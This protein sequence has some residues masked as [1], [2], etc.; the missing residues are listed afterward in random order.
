MVSRAFHFIYREIKGLHQAAYVLALFAFGSQILAVIRDR[1]L[2]HTFG[3]GGELD[4]YYTAFRIPDLLFV[5]FASILSVYVLLPF[6]ERSSTADA[7][8]NLLSQVFTLFLFVYTSIAVVLALTAPWYVSYLFPGYAEQAAEL[9]ILLQIL[10]LQPL[11][12]GISSICGVITQMHHRFVLYAIS[13]LVY[14]FGIIF[15]L[16]ALYPYFGLPGLVGGVVIGAVGH[17][18][19]Q[20]PFVRRSAVSFTAVFVF[21]W[22]EIWQLVLVALPRALT[23]S[24]HQIVLLVFISIATT[25][26]VGSVSVFQ[27]AY[28]IQSVPL[29][30]IGMSY[31][32]AAF[33]TLSHLFAKRD[34]AAFNLQ[35]LT[36]LRHIVFWSIPIIGLVVILRAHIVRVLLGSGEF[37]W[38][39][40]RLTAAVL[41]LFVVSL[42]AQAVLLLVIRAFYAGGR[43]VIPLLYSLISSVLAI[44]CAYGGLWLWRNSQELQLFVSSQFRL[45]AVPGSEVLVLAAAFTLGQ[46]VQVVM[47]L[48][49][50]RKTFSFRVYPLA[51]LLGQ[52]VIAAV[53]GAITAYGTLQFVVEGINQE[54]SIGIAL[55]GLAAGIAGTVAIV[56][57][58]WVLR[59]PEL[60]ETL[61]SFRKKILQTDFV[62][63]Q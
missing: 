29:A 42:A 22:K 12:L 58:Y 3:A 18:L 46:L 44:G 1:M 51:R 5:L 25:L 52:S 15:G 32:V 45:E 43:T 17:V 2:A 40:T 50:A 6:I 24:L 59:S 28:N 48:I 61:K 41:A 36:A 20:V 33:P 21:N 13:P 49:Q 11:L 9:A 37:D 31:S 55:Q 19:V 27:F 62:A 8:Q 63:P 4:L 60:H 47:L 23:L 30:I 10:L 38:S 16:I 54:A 35:L 57:T 7:K 53:V 14:N 56:M 39:D 34:Q 26:T